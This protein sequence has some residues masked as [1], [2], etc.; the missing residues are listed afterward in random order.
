MRE[1][2]FRFGKF[3]LIP[4]LAQLRKSGTIVRLPHQPFRVLHLLVSRAGTVVTREEIR[5]EL[6]GSETFVDFDHGINAAIRNI[7]FALNDHAEAPRYLETIP[8]RGYRFIASVERDAPPSEDAPE[9]RTTPM[10]PPV[11]TPLTTRSRRPLT[12]A[13]VLLASIAAGALVR[14]NPTPPAT[15]RVAILPFRVIGERLPAELDARAFAEEVHTRLAQLRPERIS[16]IDPNLVASRARTNVPLSELA[17]ETGADS[18]VIGT[19]RKTADGARVIVRCVDG[20]SQKELWTQT[21]ERTFRESRAFPIAVAHRVV[22]AIAAQVLPPAREEPVLRTRVN[23]AALNLY[24][25]ARVERTLPVPQQNPERALELF[26]A[27]LRVAPRFAEAWAGIGEVWLERAISSAGPHQIPAVE[28][29]RPALL[30]AIALDPNCAEAQNDYGLLLLVFDHDYAGAETAFRRAVR[31][32]PELS[33]VHSNLAWVLSAMA[34]H[35]EAIAVYH[36]AQQLDPMMLSPDRAMAVIYLMARRYDEAAAEYR[37]VELVKQNVTGVQWGLMA[38]LIAQRQYDEAA[39]VLARMNPRANVPVS[40]PHEPFEKSYRRLEPVMLATDRDY[41]G[42][43]YVLAAYY[44]QG[45]D[46]DRALEHL[47]RA[48]EAHAALTIYLN[49]D[50]RL[51]NLRSDPR[52]AARL[53]KMNLL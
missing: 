2:P 28:K 36:R 4:E 51:D 38:A 44:A 19:I 22:H 47:D 13:V 27:A 41:I 9:A 45:G 49:V 17:R 34:K 11:T 31:I 32:D 12:L 39:A 43:D 33:Q 24:R 1:A 6:W 46:R 20:H 23:A 40:L 53:R 42:H 50:P 18:L 29:A 52:F 7:R 10:T 3:E 15:H 35:D 37:E 5:Q 16:V 48:I 30:R 8:R 14:Q 25:Q 26:H 21:H